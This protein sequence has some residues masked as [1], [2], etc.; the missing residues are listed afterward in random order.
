M[1]IAIEA[2]RVATKG[3][4]FDPARARADIETAA[5]R[6]RVYDYHVRPR[7]VL[8]TLKPLLGHL[9]ELGERLN[10]MDGESWLD[11]RD[12]CWVALDDCNEADQVSRDLSELRGLVAKVE[13]RLSAVADAMNATNGREGRPSNDTRNRLFRDLR[14][15]Y[16]KHTGQKATATVEDSELG[17]RSAFVDF[18]V[19]VNSEIRPPLPLAGLGSAIRNSLYSNKSK[20]S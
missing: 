13:P 1:T 14:E 20:D 4:R 18:V 16:E 7:E 10:A 8:R 3:K 6:A 9:R 12:W 17:A 19:A 11:L 5:T 2:L 15:I